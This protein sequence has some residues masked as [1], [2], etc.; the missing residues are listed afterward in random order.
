MFKNHEICMIDV[1]FF[2]EL[3]AVKIFE[4]IKRNATFQQYLP[5]LTELKRP[6]SRQYL[7]N[8]MHLDFAHLSL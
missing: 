2:N 3:S 1:P 6:L 5:D 4:D 8:V 7:F